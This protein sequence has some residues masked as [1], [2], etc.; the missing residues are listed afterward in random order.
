MTSIKNWSFKLLYPLSQNS[1]YDSVTSFHTPYQG[2]IQNPKTLANWKKFP[3]NFPWIRPCSLSPS[4]MDVIYEWPLGFLEPF[5]YYGT[6]KILISMFLKIPFFN[7]FWS[8]TK[9]QDPLPLKRQTKQ[10][11]D[12]HR[13]H[14]IIW[15][16]NL[17]L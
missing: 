1:F 15:K 8:V 7:P 11:K 14:F 4:I 5:I 12:P 2:R 9:C 6:R 16:T 10:V 3:K 13:N 17:N